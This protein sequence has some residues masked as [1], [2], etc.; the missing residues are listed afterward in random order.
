[1]LGYFLTIDYIVCFLKPLNSAC[2]LREMMDLVANRL[3]LVTRRLVWIQ[4]VCI[5]INAVP[6][7]KG[8]T[9]TISN[10]VKC[11]Y[12]IHS[13]LKHYCT[14]PKTHAKVSD[15]EIYWSKVLCK[16]IQDPN[17]PQEVMHVFIFGKKPTDLLKVH[18]IE[19]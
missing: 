19:N 10:K 17:Y 18:D 6:T 14:E 2:L 13:H 16:Q 8:L 15:L 11:V 4:P 1:M 9:L 5:S 3:D 12:K 7:L